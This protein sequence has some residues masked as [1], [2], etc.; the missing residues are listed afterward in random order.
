MEKILK[1]IEALQYTLISFALT[2]LV[3]FLVSG[4]KWAPTATLDNG[5]DY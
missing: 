3:F 4:G 5:T 2:Y 1:Y